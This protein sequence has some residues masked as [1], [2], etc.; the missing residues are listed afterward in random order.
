MDNT[1]AYLKEKIS[2][3]KLQRNLEK[4]ESYKDIWTKYIE[5]INAVLMEY[6]KKKNKKPE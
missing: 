6:R 1:E 2:W 5:E 4:Y 3:G